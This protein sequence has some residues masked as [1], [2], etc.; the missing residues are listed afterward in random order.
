MRRAAGFEESQELPKMT[1]KKKPKVSQPEKC[2]KPRTSLYFTK[3]NGNSEMQELLKKARSSEATR[4]PLNR[5][6]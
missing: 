5:N 1:E 6:M 3:K 2:P 4:D